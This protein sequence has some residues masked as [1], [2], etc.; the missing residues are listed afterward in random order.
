MSARRAPPRRRLE[1]LLPLLV[2]PR[3]QRWRGERRRDERM[4]TALPRLLPPLPTDAEAADLMVKEEQALADAPAPK[5][6]RR[7]IKINHLE[8]QKCRNTPQKHSFASAVTRTTERFAVKECKNKYFGIRSKLYLNKI[9][10]IIR[11]FIFTIYAFASTSIYL[12][13]LSYHSAIPQQKCQSTDR[14]SS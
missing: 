6:T 1:L 10:K 3:W 5:R 8:T 14:G 11:Y 4:R 12:C 9:F 7:R 13:I 2:N